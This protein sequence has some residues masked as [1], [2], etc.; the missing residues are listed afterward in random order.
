MSQPTQAACMIQN[1]ES[2]SNP[3]EVPPSDDWKPTV[4]QY[5]ETLFPT[6]ERYNPKHRQFSP[7]QCGNCKHAN[8]PDHDGNPPPTQA[9]EMGDRA[10]SAVSL[11]QEDAMSA[12]TARSAS[13]PRDFPN[14]VIMNGHTVPLDAAFEYFAAQIKARDALEK[15]RKEIMA[16]TIPPPKR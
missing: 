9:T 1:S 11:S 2:V 10:H 15:A 7:C 12:S 3:Q 13:E 4:G 8:D 14:A 6:S 5:L 16:K